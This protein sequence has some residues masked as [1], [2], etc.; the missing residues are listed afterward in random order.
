MPA[1]RSSPT[2]SLLCA[3]LLVC[4]ASLAST[5]DAYCHHTQGKEFECDCGKKP[6]DFPL[7]TKLWRKHTSADLKKVTCIP[8][9]EFK[10]F[11]GPLTFTGLENLVEIELKAFLGSPFLSMSGKYPKLTRLGTAAFYRAG[12]AGKTE[13]DL[14][15]APA[16]FL[17][18]DWA[19]YQ[20]KGRIVIQGDYFDLSQIGIVAFFE[21]GSN[22]SIVDLSE[23]P[24]LVA[25]H[26]Q[27]FYRYTGVVKMTGAMPAIDEI[28]GSC[29]A[30][31]SNRDNLIKIACV[32][33]G[34]L[35]ISGDSFKG[36]SGSR[37]KI[38]EKRTCASNLHL[39]NR[40]EL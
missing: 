4:V 33:T 10:N 17:V 16:L 3:A 28:G 35:S 25:V 24:S 26:N 9:E 39:K 38:G 36:M 12:V 20:F 2:V 37:D 30:G 6:G 32:S 21:G 1:A 29:F 27:A 7:T 14:S 19:F 22:D 31:A 34:G 23:V 40:K 8:R 13:I 18:G 15:G 11:D 5:A